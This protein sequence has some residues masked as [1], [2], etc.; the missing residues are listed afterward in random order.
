M[1][2]SAKKLKGTPR[3]PAKP[4]FMDDL[5]AAIAKRGAPNGNDKRD[6]L[7]GSVLRFDEPTTP[8]DDD[9]WKANTLDQERN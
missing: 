9:E 7:R 6:S 3:R 8:V 2:T 4:V 5:N 1:T